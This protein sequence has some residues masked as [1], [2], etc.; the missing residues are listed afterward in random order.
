ML[1]KEDIIKLAIEHGFQVGRDASGEYVAPKYEDSVGSM[2]A[3]VQAAYVLGQQQSI[4]DGH[5][6]VPLEITRQQLDAAKVDLMRDGEIDPMLKGV[7]L[8][9]LTAAPCASQ[10]AVFEAQAGLCLKGEAQPVAVPDGWQ[11]A[12]VFAR[13]ALVDAIQIAPLDRLP[14]MAGAAVQQI[15]AMLSAVQKKQGAA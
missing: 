2:V 5:V 6:L 15:D 7:Y 1:N 14:Q 11:A 4:P 13:D 10:S 12:M 9:M 3:L 8:A